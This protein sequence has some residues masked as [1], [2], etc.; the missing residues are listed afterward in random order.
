MALPAWAITEPG[1]KQQ[2][3]R[4]T[5]KHCSK[6]ALMKVSV[7]DQTSRAWDGCSLP[8]LKLAL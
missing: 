7:I 2:M 3:L 4:H 6:L 8:F 1:P 5:V